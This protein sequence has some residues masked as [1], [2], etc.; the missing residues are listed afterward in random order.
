MTSGGF[1]SCGNAAAESGWA[2]MKRLVPPVA[3]SLAALALFLWWWS[4]P[5]RVVARQ[6]NGLF[7]AAEVRAETGSILRGTRA[8]A[9]EKYL[10]PN[11]RLRGSVEESRGT[12]SRSSLS[13]MYG[14]LA[15]YAKR[16][17]IGKPEIDSIVV[18]GT[19]ATVEAR[20]D[21]IV[22]ADNRRPLDGIQHVTMI[23]T[24]GEEGWQLS[25]ASWTESGR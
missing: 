7:E 23:W 5:E 10:A 24:K 4:R 9:V 15:R 22:E 19:R 25:E 1:V 8:Q 18:D 20:I 17:T 6:V 14:A 12:F 13:S 16:I 11:V 21:A 3:A 2:E